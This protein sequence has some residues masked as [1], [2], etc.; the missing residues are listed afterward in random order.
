[1]KKVTLLISRIGLLEFSS[2]YNVE[3]H[4]GNASYRHFKSIWVMEK[5][6]TG[7]RY[8]EFVAFILFVAVFTNTMGKSEKTHD[9]RKTALRACRAVIK[10]FK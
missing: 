8:L 10:V 2:I 9:V 4:S 5:Q 3:L 7:S 6:T 1:M